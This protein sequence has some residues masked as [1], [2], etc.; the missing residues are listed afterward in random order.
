MQ[1]VYTTS[2]RAL[3]LL[4]V[5]KKELKKRQNIH[6]FTANLQKNLIIKNKKLNSQLLQKELQP[7]FEISMLL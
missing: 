3:G 2:F 7:K 6:F 4:Q 1:R 5:Q